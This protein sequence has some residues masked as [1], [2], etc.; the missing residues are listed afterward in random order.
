VVQSRLDE[1]EA[2]F[3]Q[4]VDRGL[5]QATRRY[6]EHLGE[7]PLVPEQ[8]DLWTGNL[9]LDDDGRLGVVDW[10][11]AQPQGLPA[12]DLVYFLTDLA[13]MRAGAY[14]SRQ[15][16]PTY[17]ATLDPATFLGRVR[18]ECLS[19]YAAGIGLDPAALRALSVLTWLPNA[20]WEYRHPATALPR[21]LQLW[22]EEL[23]ADGT[24]ACGQSTAC[25]K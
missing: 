16:R 20:V 13:F 15:F 23:R 17:R 21:F 18:A 5:L 12:V 1:F 2:C 11:D 25:S 22:E 24:T 6:L 3:V 8:R 14:A 7:F 9:L 19:R 10:E 4:T